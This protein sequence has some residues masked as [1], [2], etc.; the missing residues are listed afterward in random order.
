[1]TTIQITRRGV[2]ERGQPF[3]HH[4]RA[5]IAER[6]CSDLRRESWY[7]HSAN[8]QHMLEVKG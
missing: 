7:E 8:Q 5:W 1:M 2:G 3:N 6:Y 4:V